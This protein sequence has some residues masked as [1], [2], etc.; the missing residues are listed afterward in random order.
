MIHLI[1]LAVCAAVVA[2]SK[3]GLI[4]ERKVLDKLKAQLAAKRPSRPVDR[5]AN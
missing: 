5:T 4:R 2:V 3:V 1:G